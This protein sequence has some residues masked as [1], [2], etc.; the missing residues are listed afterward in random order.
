MIEY[1]LEIHPD[2]TKLVYCR[3]E[4]RRKDQPEEVSNKFDFLGYS[5]RTRT[6]IDKFNRMRM[7]SFTPAISDKSKKK[8]KEEIRELTIRNRTNDSAEEIAK[9]LQSKIV[10]WINYY[11]KF[12]KSELCDVFSI[13]NNAIIKWIR[14]K[15]KITSTK[16][17]KQKFKELQ[18]NKVFA[19]FSLL[20][21]PVK[22]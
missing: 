5:F 7:D 16:K 15:Y 1:G 18:A 2:K 9:L 14:K 3:Q 11:G 6:T 8:I 12:R 19:H 20:Q 4:E 13:L 21:Q 10:G 17:A 22:H